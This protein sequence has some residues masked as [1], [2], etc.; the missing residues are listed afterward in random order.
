MLRDE[1]LLAR[2]RGRSVNIFNL[3]CGPAREI[4]D[5]LA[6]HDICDQTRFRLLDFNR[7]TLAHTSQVLG[8]L[9]RQYNRATQI[10]LV[11]KSVHQILKEAHKFQ[12]SEGKYDV[13]YCAGLF[14]YLSD[15]VCRRLIQIFY[16]MAAP[17][18]LVVVTNVDISNPSRNWMEYVLDWHLIYRD[19]R[20]F[21]VLVPDRVKPDTAVVR[22]VGT[23]VNIVL[24]IRKPANG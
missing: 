18:G 10:D 2:R 9:K 16:D 1:T 24:E 8:A 11:E 21:R 17:G 5:Y 22:S 4:Q 19:A 20:R 14:D 7:E 13:V 15:Q 3:G 12:S 6:H 23:G